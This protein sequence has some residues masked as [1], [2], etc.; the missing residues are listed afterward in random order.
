MNARR[1]VLLA[2]FPALMGVAC[3]GD[4]GDDEVQEAKDLMEEADITDLTGESDPVVDA[5]DNVFN[6]KYIEVEVGTTVTFDNTGENV[7][8][9]LPVEEGAFEPIEASEFDPGDIG[10]VTF[11]EVGDFPYYCSLHGTKTKGM[12]GGVRVVE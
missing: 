7:H 10:T 9:V 12:V 2:A 4:S 5:R 11:D 8:N 6:D 3:G 1:L